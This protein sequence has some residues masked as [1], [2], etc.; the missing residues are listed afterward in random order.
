MRNLDTIDHRPDDTWDTPDRHRD[1]GR[2]HDSKGC[3][4]IS[5]VLVLLSSAAISV[6]S[7]YDRSEDFPLDPR[8]EKLYNQLID[9]ELRQAWE[10]LEPGQF[11]YEPRREMTQGVTEEIRVRVSRDLSSSIDRSI[12]KGK[13]VVEK[14]KVNGS[15]TAQLTANESEL[16]VR[17]KSSSPQ[18]L[19][20][21]HTDWIWWVT[22]LRAG[23]LRLL[24]RIT[25]HI[26]LSNGHKEDR[27]VFVKEILINV[28]ASSPI[29][30]FFSNNW[31]WLA[32]VALLVV[33][34]TGAC[35]LTLAKARASSPP[36][37]STEDEEPNRTEG[38]HDVFL[39]YNRDDGA[40]VRRIARLLE[41]EGLS[42]WL[43]EWEL[44]P[45]SPWQR[46]L[47]GK[48]EEIAT[49]AVFI[50][51]QGIGPWQRMELEALVREFNERGCRVIPVILEEC[52]EDPDVPNFLEGM[53]W[54][55]F[56]RTD[57]EPLQQLI[58]GI[59]G[60]RIS[61]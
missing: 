23:E 9:K 15:M 10:A 18:A 20:G 38:K 7:L 8:T 30:R 5:W 46:I 31:R 56:R 49:A 50:G 21:K 48:I 4:P 52:K 47:E 44:R 37:T 59:T 22:P 36:P 42:P 43:D 1:A 26:R 57:P 16:E 60:E 17:S 13:S 27:D 2:D 6:V 58:W 54:V 29:H 25:A 34:G 24:L 35:L 53:T 3:N 39:S 40:A 32:G 14:L 11:A 28:R 51:Q 41:E 33:L 45:G 61:S 19:V 12:F 55:D